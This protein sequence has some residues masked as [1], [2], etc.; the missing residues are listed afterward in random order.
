MAT[1]AGLLILG[2]LAALALFTAGG[3]SNS[4]LL[5]AHL[6]YRH[7][8]ETERRHAEFGR[9]MNARWMREWEASFVPR[10]EEQYLK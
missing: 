1:L 10:E 8:R 4:V 3:Y 2:V 9:K 6:L 5:I 7:A